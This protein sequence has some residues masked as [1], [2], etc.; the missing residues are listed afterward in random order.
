[1]SVRGNAGHCLGSDRACE[2]V[3]SGGAVVGSGK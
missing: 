2:G 1:M 3:H